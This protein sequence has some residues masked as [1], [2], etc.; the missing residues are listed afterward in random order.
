MTGDLIRR[1][2]DIRD[3]LTQRKGPCEGHASQGQRPQEKPN[4][5]TP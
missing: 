5:P 1:K 3:V 2:R 4:L